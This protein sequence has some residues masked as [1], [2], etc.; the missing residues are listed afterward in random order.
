M[1]DLRTLAD[2]GITD[3]SILHMV[4]RLR[5][6]GASLPFGVLSVHNLEGDCVTGSGIPAKPE[7]K[8]KSFGRG[9]NIIGRCD[10]PA[11]KSTQVAQDQAMRKVGF[12][13][14]TLK[15][16]STFWCH[17]CD[18]AKFRA[19]NLLLAGGKAEFRFQKRGDDEVKG[20]QIKSG[21]FPEYIM[22]SDEGEKVPYD[23]IEI[24]AVELKESLLH[25]MDC[26]TRVRNSE[27]EEVKECGH[28]F[29]KGCWNK[30]A[31]LTDGVVHECPA[32]SVR[33]IPE[34]ELGEFVY[35]QELAY[36]FEKGL[37][38]YKCARSTHHLFS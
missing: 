19:S 2:Y 11:C 26:G 33:F 10:N 29:H 13:T 17:V 20:V 4:L 34:D 7:N 15:P 25:C 24:T 32:C 3:G 14:I 35:N 23:F 22:F 37:N 28:V 21:P 27:D 1:E 8:W 36:Y 5:G 16:S 30:Y 31:D 6:G 9:L 38:L 12:T 18:K